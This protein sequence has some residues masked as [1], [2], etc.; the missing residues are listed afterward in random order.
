[1]RFLRE[2]ERPFA[3]DV[4]L[5]LIGPAEDRECLS[6]EDLRRDRVRGQTSGRFGEGVAAVRS[7]GMQRGPCA[8]DARAEVAVVPEYVTHQELR[9]NRAAG[10]VAA[11]RANRLVTL[12]VQS[13]DLTEDVRLREP[14]PD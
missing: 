5:D 10:N 3:D 11:G 14:L 6:R 9:A 2:A 4:A 13:R 1:P 7:V 12:G 8:E